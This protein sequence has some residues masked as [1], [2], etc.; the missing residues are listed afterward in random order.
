MRPILPTYL[1]LPEYKFLTEHC[2]HTN[3]NVIE[4]LNLFFHL[5]HLIRN[6]AAHE[7]GMWMNLCTFS[8]ASLYGKNRR[9]ERIFIIK[10]IGF[11]YILLYITLLVTRYV[12]YIERHSCDQFSVCSLHEQETMTEDQR[13]LKDLLSVICTCASHSRWRR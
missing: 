12:K 1:Q 6:L 13:K 3:M 11:I 5:I 4:L 10:W 8:S 7:H 2:I 9:N